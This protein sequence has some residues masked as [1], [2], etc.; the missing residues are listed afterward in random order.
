M[1]EVCLLMCLSVTVSVSQIYREGN[2]GVGKLA[3][4]SL[5]KRLNFAW[6][7]EIPNFLR[8]IFLGAE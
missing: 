8:N 1:V 7:D 4:I 5:D 2:A 3:N 6:L